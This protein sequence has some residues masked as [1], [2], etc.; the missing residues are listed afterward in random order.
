MLLA[1]LGK[2]PGLEPERGRGEARILA[3]IL[4]YVFHSK[5]HFYIRYGTPA[6][7]DLLQAEVAE[8][9]AFILDRV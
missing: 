7:L 8:E 1:E 6:S 9:T 4:T 3:D 5:L 2:L